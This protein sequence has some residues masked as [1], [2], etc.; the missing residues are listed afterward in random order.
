MQGFSGTSLKKAYLFSTAISGSFR[1]SV[2]H[3]GE[4]FIARHTHPRGEK[5]IALS[6]NRPGVRGL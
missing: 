6:K 3:L 1:N 5:V 4:A 2:E